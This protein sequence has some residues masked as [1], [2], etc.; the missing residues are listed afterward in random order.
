MTPHLRLTRAL[1]ERIHADLSRPHTHAAERVAFLTC[2]PARLSN[3]ALMLLAVDLHPV[4]DDHYEEDSTVGAMVGAAAFRSMLQLAYNSQISVLHV[5]RHDHRGAPW[6]SDVD[7]SEAR[8]Y[9]PDFWKV[10]PGFPHGTLVLSHD[11]AAGLVWLPA[12][13]TPARLACISIVGA[14]IQEIHYR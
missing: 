10:R 9:I 13:R 12:T 7:L 2:R 3:D 8:K 6:F 14:P 1:L 5:H 4:A 11:C